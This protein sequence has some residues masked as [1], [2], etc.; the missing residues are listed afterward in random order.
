M[1]TLNLPNEGDFPWD[2]NPAITAINDELVSTTAAVGNVV[3]SKGG[4]GGIGSLDGSG[5]QPTGQIAPSVLP[6]GTVVRNAITGVWDATGDPLVDATGTTDST[7][8][9]QA[10]IDAARAAGGGV[11]QLPAGTIIAEPVMKHRVS[12]R[13]R[14]KR[15]TNLKAKSGST[16]TGIITFA[17]G[18]NQA[19]YI[20]DLRIVGNGNLGQ[21]GVHCNATPI[22]PDNNGGWWEGGMR[23]VQIEGLTSDSTTIAACI[24]F[25]S[26]ATVGELLPT[27]FMRFE[28]VFCFSDNYGR[29]IWSDAQ[30]GQIEWDSCE[31]D[32]PTPA[33][34]GG[35]DVWLEA[36]YAWT[37]TN[38][39]FQNNLTGVRLYSVNEVTFAGCYWENTG[40]A[41]DVLENSRSVVLI[42]PHLAN[43]GYISSS[44]ATG[45]LV[46]AQTA[47]RVHIYGGWVPGQFSRSLVA[48]NT[49]TIT[50]HGLEFPSDKVVSASGMTKQVSVISN[51][52]TVQ[53]GAETVIVNT[54]TDPITK[55]GAG[56][57]RLTG[58]R[59]TFLAFNGP[60]TFSEDNPDGVTNLKL[61][62]KGPVLTIPR[63][64]TA[65]FQRFDLAHN[66]VLISTS[67]PGGLG[68]PSTVDPGMIRATDSMGVGAANA[69]IYLRAIGGGTISK[70]GMRVGV[71]SGNISVAVYRNSGTGRSSIPGTRIATT[72]SI[73]CPAVGYAEVSLGSTVTLNDGDWIGISADNTTAQIGSLL[74]AG[75][76]SNLGLGRQYRQPTAHP[77]PSAPSSL[78]ATIGYTYC[79][80]GTP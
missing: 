20:E 39:T 23:R 68:F 35:A 29:G 63:D 69:A 80:V 13:G 45:A 27:Q 16:N 19:T 14:G 72:G 33:S 42:N 12:L 1:A 38:C 8:R 59:L 22:A 28:H 15:A 51:E 7:S 26:S 76:D 6:Q 10:Y 5:K 53:P 17:T 67:T 77:L 54:S 61:N 43:A 57:R 62:G 30:V 37:F 31:F 65:V 70:I 2:L 66:W 55:I 56:S 11:V 52:V 9:V 50:Q 58:D 46:R 60:I 3:S 32:G 25:S 47:S 74:S 36:G 48:D 64:G 24:R 73:A 21:H 40:R 78:V 44:D 4:A 34:R 79:L 18:Y 49:A 71:S 41:V 75:A